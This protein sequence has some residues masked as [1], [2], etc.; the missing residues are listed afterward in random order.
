[1]KALLEN[2]KIEP[3]PNPEGN[4]LPADVL[5]GHGLLVLVQTGYEDEKKL[6]LIPP[7]SVPRR[8]ARHHHQPQAREPR[9]LRIR[10]SLTCYR[11]AAVRC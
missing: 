5:R 6:W 3:I 8:T 7:E 10:F 1:M 9:D 11:S 2:G 4:S